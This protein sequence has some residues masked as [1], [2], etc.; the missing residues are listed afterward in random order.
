[1]TSARAELAKE[2]FWSSVQKN[3][4]KFIEDTYSIRTKEATYSKLVLNTSQAYV[5][6]L[7]QESQDK[8][9]YIRDVILKYRQWGCSTW[10]L[11][12]AATKTVSRRNWRTLITAHHKERAKVMFR[13]FRTFMQQIPKELQPVFSSDN[14]KE[15]FLTDR[16]S[17]ATISTAKTPEF[18]RGDMFNW[19]HMTEVDYYIGEGGSLFTQLTAGLSMIPKFPGMGV[20]ME[21]TANGVEGELYHF[22]MQ[23]LEGKNEYGF[24]PIFVNWK[25]DRKCE[26]TLH[27][28]EGERQRDWE[29]VKAERDNCK[30]CHYHRK[31]WAKSFATEELLERRR[32]YKLTWEQIIWY[33]WQCMTD[34]QGD[35]RKMGQE[36]PCDWEEAFIASGSPVW[37]LKLLEKLKLRSYAGKLFE[38]PAEDFTEW[39]ELSESTILRP[40]EDPYLML[41]KRPRKDHRYMI[42]ADSSLGTET[43]N[44]CAAIILDMETMGI[45]GLM[46]GRIDP[47]NYARILARIGKYYNMAMIAPEQQNTGYAVISVLEDIYPN[48]YLKYR[49]SATGWKPQDTPGFSTDRATRP[50]M[51]QVGRQLLNA[52]AGDVDTL[53]DLI[54]SS[55]LIREMM[56]FTHGKMQKG[57]AQ[58]SAGMGDDIVMSWLI[59]ITAT[60]QELG[61]GL[62]DDAQ[63]HLQQVKLEEE[64]RIK[65]PKDAEEYFAELEKFRAGEHERWA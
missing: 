56:G 29:V 31:Q 64:K 19:W 10:C 45:V 30:E 40:G 54:P 47:K 15:I 2:N 16:N 59:A 13:Q 4:K 25:Y 7:Q 42:G 5:D 43:S 11:A 24:R 41:W 32:K 21:S 63:S 50:F 44:P 61:I 49:L 65:T 51:V 38:C 14:E 62:N 33:H 18:V 1:M 37:S 57:K 26:R 20:V 39:T 58:A 3:E 17:S 9:L 22:W 6:R 23:M 27:E 46:H 8:G 53:S 28:H 60:H 48:L 35:W 36:F 52:W 12:K 55:A 34:L